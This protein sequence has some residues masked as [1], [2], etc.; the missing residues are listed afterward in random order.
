MKSCF[1]FSRPREPLLNTKTLFHHF[2]GKPVSPN[3]RIG[4]TEENSF[5][6]VPAEGTAQR[7]FFLNENFHWVLCQNIHESFWWIRNTHPC[8]VSP[9]ENRR[10]LLCRCSSFSA[11]SS[12]CWILTRWPHPFSYLPLGLISTHSKCQGR[13]KGWNAPFTQRP[14]RATYGLPALECAII[15]PSAG[16]QVSTNSSKKVIELIPSTAYYT[17]CTLHYV[18]QTTYN[19]RYTT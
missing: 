16:N 11:S 15:W 10:L 14:G 2:L 4:A 3:V 13:K 18:P 9:E 1:P 6:N 5:L 17:P 8:K 7:D 19:I 12:C